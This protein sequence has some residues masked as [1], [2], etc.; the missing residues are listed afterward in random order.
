MARYWLHNGFLQVEGE[1][2][3]KSLGNFVTIR[4]LLQDWP[5]EVLRLNMLRSHYRQ[6]T[7]WTVAGLE[8]SWKVLE[9]WTSSTEFVAGGEGTFGPSV[10][11][12]LSDD[13]NTPQ[14]ITEL[15][16]LHGKGDFAA[17]AG[18]LQAL[19]FK[20]RPESRRTIDKEKVD[21]LVAERSQARKTRNFA[22]ADRIR[23]EL[24][25]MG[26]ELEDH[27]DGPTTWK[28]KR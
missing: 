9:S 17:L 20:Q 22:E 6:P 13:L 3:A 25:A 11:E 15:H 7:D 28:V 23:K 4:E 1:K 8:E 2:M 12:S 10:L 26:V 27:R 16:A 21:A 14:M 18:N 24:A 19:G 5:G